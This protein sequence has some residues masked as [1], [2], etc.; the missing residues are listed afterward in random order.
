MVGDE[1]REGTLDGLAV[2]VGPTGRR[3]DRY[4]GVKLVDHAGPVPAGVLVEDRAVRRLE[5]EQ[6]RATIAPRAVPDQGVLE[7][8]HR[9]RIQLRG[10][11]GRQG[12]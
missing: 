5:V 12:A 10:E 6:Q 1:R 4:I 7:V 2:D 3:H 9:D 8:G 11:E